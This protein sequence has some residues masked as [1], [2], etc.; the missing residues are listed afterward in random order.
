MFSSA[1]KTSPEFKPQF[2]RQRLQNLC[3]IFRLR[4]SR[5]LRESVWFLRRLRCWR[6]D[7]RSLRRL[8]L[9]LLIFLQGVAIDLFQRFL[10][11][12]RVELMSDFMQFPEHK[13][14]MRIERILICFHALPVEIFLTQKA[15][16]SNN[17]LFRLRL[18]R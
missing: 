12:L 16:A 14:H 2:C 6:N 17:R 18:L 9:P 5:R 7:W 10:A 8:P 4:L 15:Q 11:Q 3:A 13:I 1:T